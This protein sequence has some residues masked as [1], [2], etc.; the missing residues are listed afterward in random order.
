MGM[1]YALYGESRIPLPSVH[2]RKKKTNETRASL[3]ALNQPPFV[4]HKKTHHIDVFFFV[5]IVAWATRISPGEEKKI[6]TASP[7][8]PFETTLTMVHQRQSYDYYVNFYA[9]HS[10]HPH[11]FLHRKHPSPH[12]F[13]TMHL[14]QRASVQNIPKKGKGVVAVGDIPRGA[15]ILQEEALEVVKGGVS[16]DKGLLVNHLLQN[17]HQLALRNPAAREIIFSMYPDAA[18]SKTD[19]KF[20][21]PNEKRPEDTNYPQP[22]VDELNHLHNILSCNAFLL[23]DLTGCEEMCFA[24]FPTTAR[25]N[26]S[27]IPNCSYYFKGRD[28]FV[29]AIVDIPKGAELTITY[30][31]GYFSKNKRVR[32]LSDGYNFRCDCTRCSR[33]SETDVVLDALCCDTPG[34]EGYVST[35]FVGTSRCVTCKTGRSREWVEGRRKEVT[36]LA[37]TYPERSDVL[38]LVHP[39]SDDAYQLYCRLMSAM[40]RHLTL[41]TLQADTRRIGIAAAK[42][43][44]ACIQTMIG[45]EE[46]ALLTT[47]KIAA[48]CEPEES[49]AFQAKASKMCETLRGDSDYAKHFPGWAQRVQRVR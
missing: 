18:T 28:I 12:F 17:V 2:L 44:L 39:K 33:Q 14:H 5:N 49:L 21:D 31:G 40:Q 11:H 9:N 10:I 3:S 7:A 43:R 46:E 37:N 27:C 47:V 13:S 1:L 35:D 45:C 30:T 36:R 8:P 42:K 29:R 32:Y 20:R 19:F 22:L 41:G 23:E 26:H 6:H 48:F 34:C 24:L 4:V 38:Q 15:L 16:K 25:F